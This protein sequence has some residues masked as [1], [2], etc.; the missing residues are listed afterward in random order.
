[1]TKREA[2]AYFR[3]SILPLVRIDYEQ[4]GQV[5]HPARAEAW[6]NYTDN[7]Y[8]NGYITDRQVNTWVNPF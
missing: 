6:S 1:M 4:D 3:A 7:L 5:D 2:L 8:R